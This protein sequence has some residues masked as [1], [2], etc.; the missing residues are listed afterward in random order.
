MNLRNMLLAIF[1]LFPANAILAGSAGA[2]AP[3][4]IIL[5]MADD[6]GY[7]DVGF[8]GNEKIKTPSI[9]QLAAE[10]VVFDRFYTSASIC[11]PS[12]AAA[13]TGRHHYRTGVLAAHTAGLRSGEVTI[14]EALKENGYATGFFGKWHMGWVRP[15]DGPF[16]GHKHT[17]Y[18]GGIRVPSIVA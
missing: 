17:H 7:G 8:T 5:I 16:R 1:I 10:G 9:D 2:D 11:S 12:R 13:L 3:P 4:N 6:L 15:E 18:E 14:A